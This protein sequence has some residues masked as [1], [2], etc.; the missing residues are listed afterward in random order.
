MYGTYNHTGGNNLSYDSQHITYRP[1]IHTRRANLRVKFQD[2]YGFTVEGNVDDVNILNEVREKVR[3]QA[4][5]WLE[6]EANKG[7]NW[8]LQTHVSSSLKPSRKLSALANAVTLKRLI[9][10]GIPPSLRPK[11]WFSLS[12]AAKKKSMAPESYYSDLIR[13]IDGQ[14]TPAA[15]QI[16]QVSPF[17]LI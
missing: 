16:D 1:S 11:V 17:L 8:Y 14:V 13:A 9:R 5:A 3:K 7:A 15:K 12:G 4:K 6:M 2:L 10:K